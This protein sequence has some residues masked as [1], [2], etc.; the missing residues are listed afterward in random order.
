MRK[1]IVALLTMAVMAV[2]MLAAAAPAFAQGEGFDEGVGGSD[3]QPG[4]TEKAQSPQAD[5]PQGKPGGTRR[6]NAGSE[7]DT[8]DAL[9]GF[10]HRVDAQQE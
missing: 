3:P 2:A 8:H 5:P 9:T 4:Q 7:H 6:A 10:G 1:R